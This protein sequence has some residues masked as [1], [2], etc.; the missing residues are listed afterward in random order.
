M[1]LPSAFAGWHEC[2]NSP[3]PNVNDYTPNSD[4]TISISGWE[5]WVPLGAS[6]AYRFNATHINSA[7]T[8]KQMNAEYFGLVVIKGKYLVITSKIPLTNY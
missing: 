7:G 1:T 8:S 4:D 2:V 3:I 5:G 6:K